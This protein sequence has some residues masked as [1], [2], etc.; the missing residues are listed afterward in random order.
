[1]NANT[2]LQAG[3]KSEADAQPEANTQPETNAQ[4]TDAAASPR[5]E[6]NTAPADNQPRPGVETVREILNTKINPFVSAGLREIFRDPTNMYVRPPHIPTPSTP[7]VGLSLGTV[8]MAARAD[9]DTVLAP[10][11]PFGS[12]ASSY[13]RSIER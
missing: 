1:M 5:P 3:I 6:P 12:W 4:P 9:V 2:Q 10:R 13:W 7:P 8:R 11:I